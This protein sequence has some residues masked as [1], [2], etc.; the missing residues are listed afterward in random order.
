MSLSEFFEQFG[1]E[2]QCERSLEQARWPH[3]FVCPQCGGVH[4]SQFFV[5]GTHYWQCRDCRHQTSLRS[6]TIF[7][8]SKLPLHK[9]FQSMFLISQSKNHVSALELK[10]Q[11]GV[12]WPTAWRVK[13]KL[14]QVMAEREAGRV[15][16]GDVVIDDAYL[17]GEHR[18]K[19]GRGSE[20][21]VPFLA[22]VELNEKGHPLYARFDVVGSF[23]KAAIGR[24]SKKFLASDSRVVSDGL[25]CFPAVTQSGATHLPEVVGSGRCSIDM[26]CFAWINTLLGIL[27]TSIAGTYHAFKFRKYGRRYLAERQ[28]LFNRRYDMKAILPRLLYAGAATGPRTEA[29]LRAAEDSC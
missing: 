6:G 17:G 3:G 29:W 28:Y 1:T 24:W 5:K 23:S 25:S 8:S 18:G 20:N 11:L 22:A 12:S 27:K 26:P 19:A 14:M 13:Q 10:R 2:Q 4:A 9:W 15:L 21:K 16:R 7:H